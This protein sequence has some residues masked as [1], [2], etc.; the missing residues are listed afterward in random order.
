VEL[1]TVHCILLAVSALLAALQCCA[2]APVVPAVIPIHATSNYL[3]KS[4]QQFQRSNLM[5]LT[6]SNMQPGSHVLW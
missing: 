5:G 6:M 4:V 1:G 3:S 2:V